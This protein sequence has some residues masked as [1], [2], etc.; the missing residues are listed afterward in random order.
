MALESHV[1]M[2]PSLGQ[3]KQIRL[4]ISA[5]DIKDHI[6]SDHLVIKR[7][8]D[9]ILITIQDME[10][11]PSMEYANFMG[12]LLEYKILELPKFDLEVDFI[13]HEELQEFTIS[14]TQDGELT[15]LYTSHPDKNH[16]QERLRV[17]WMKRIA[18]IESI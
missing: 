7:D 4:W 14:F 13:S 3:I 9:I 2:L 18:Q 12:F 10:T 5:N 1:W 17:E 8:E 11:D 16:A 6:E 15:L